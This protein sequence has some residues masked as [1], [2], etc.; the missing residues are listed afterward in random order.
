[1]WCWY[2]LSQAIIGSKLSLSGVSFPGLGFGAALVSGIDVD[3]NTYNGEAVHSYGLH[4]RYRNREKICVAT[5][6]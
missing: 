3:G 2:A 1:M 4:V 5:S 6:S